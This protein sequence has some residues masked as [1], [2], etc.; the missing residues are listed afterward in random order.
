MITEY[1][2]EVKGSMLK[3]I[4]FN[5]DRF[6]VSFPRKANIP[7]LTVATWVRNYKRKNGKIMGQKKRKQLWPAEKMFNFLC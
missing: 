4:L 6:V 2:Q 3:K 5:P 1:S 7:S